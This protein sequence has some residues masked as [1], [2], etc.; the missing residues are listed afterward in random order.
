MACAAS[1]KDLVARADAVILATP[2]TVTRAAQE[3]SITLLVSKSFGS[4]CSWRV[5]ATLTR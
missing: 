2:Q 3:V 1:I 4:S 5:C